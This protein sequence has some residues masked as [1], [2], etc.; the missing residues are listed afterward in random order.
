LQAAFPSVN[1]N[2]MN[3]ARGA[4]DVVVAATCWYQYMPQVSTYC[5]ATLSQGIGCR[6]AVHD[7]D[8]DMSAP[9]PPTSMPIAAGD[10]VVV[11]G[12]TEYM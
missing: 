6:Y 10:L 2:V 1:V 4:S 11:K 5:F 8:E 12:I 9:F 3:L 7:D